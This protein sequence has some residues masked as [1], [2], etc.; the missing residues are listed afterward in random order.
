M[1]AAVLIAARF[2][3]DRT[4]MPQITIRLTDEQHRNLQR[5]AKQQRMKKSAYVRA[6]LIEEPV[7]TVDD[8]CKW[9]ES[10]RG[11]RLMRAG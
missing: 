5:R 9:G 3:C 8:L 2:A 1:I 11:R 6:R 7:E 4:S 10:L